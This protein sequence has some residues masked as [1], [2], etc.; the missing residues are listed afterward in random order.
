MFWVAEYPRRNRFS[1]FMAA[2]SVARSF[3]RMIF[4]D[5]QARWNIHPASVLTGS[6]YSRADE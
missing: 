1:Y 6:H 2:V 3:T 4:K 5:F